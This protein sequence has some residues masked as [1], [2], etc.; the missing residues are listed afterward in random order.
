MNLAL[1]VAKIFASML[2]VKVRCTVANSDP[3]V[4]SRQ[5]G[6]GKTAVMFGREHL[7]PRRL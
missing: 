4:R 5:L 2:F 1:A 7:A 3:F 6:T